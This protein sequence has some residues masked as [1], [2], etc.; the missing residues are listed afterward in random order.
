MIRIKNIEKTYGRL[1]V[2]NNVS[3]N[4]HPGKI[5]A[6]LGPNG[7]GKTTLIKSILGM[8]IPD[9]G[10][11]FIGEENVRNN[12]EY[13]SSINYMPQISNFPENLTLNDLIKLLTNIRGQKGN[14]H[15]Y[16]KIF[17]LESFL[18]KRVKHLS[19][20]TK[21]KANIM[22]ACMFNNDIMIMDE[23]TSGLDPV[24]MIRL[25]ELIRSKKREG[26]T[27]LITTHIM[28]LVEELADEIIFLLEG[29]VY[30]QGN[31]SQ[32]NAL[33]GTENLEHAIASILNEPD[34]SN[35]IKSNGTYV[36]SMAI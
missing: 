4:I 21:Q 33:C 3:L 6:I 28:S 11:I 14:P 16:I 17:G 24:A 36:K 32:L 22:L 10:D 34:L 30:Y 31:L 29:K 9:K 18:Q 2:L 1:K 5:T 8:V 27:I 35:S 26:K 7:S 15:Y 23:P 25:K 12:W 13:R 19:G 20:G